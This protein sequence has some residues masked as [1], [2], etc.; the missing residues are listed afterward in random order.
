MQGRDL[1]FWSLACDTSNKGRSKFHLF[2]S[3]PWLPFAL[4]AYFAVK[5]L[6]LF[7]LFP[8]ASVVI[9]SS[10]RREKD[11]KVLTTENIEGT[12]EIIRGRRNINVSSLLHNKLAKRRRLAC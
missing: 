9:S 11:R 4:F 3:T 5:K 1:L 10:L 6:F 7:S 8:R 12:E 2:Q